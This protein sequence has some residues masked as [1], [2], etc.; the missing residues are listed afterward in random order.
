MTSGGRS[1]AYLRGED[2][3]AG[4]ARARRDHHEPRTVGRSWHTPRLSR[5]PVVFLRTWTEGR[6]VTTF[7]VEDD[8]STDS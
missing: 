8:V 2:V 7:V 3:V 4:I 6:R 5:G 1:S